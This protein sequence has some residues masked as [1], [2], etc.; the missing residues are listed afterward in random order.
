[1]DLPEVFGQTEQVPT[2]AGRDRLVGRCRLQHRREPLGIG[3][4]V[5]QV[6]IGV[7]R[8][9]TVASEP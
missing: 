1:M 8:A 4:Q 5:L 7:H 9:A 2:R 3:G 6:G